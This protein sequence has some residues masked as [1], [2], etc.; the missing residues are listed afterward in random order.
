MIEKIKIFI[1][2]LIRFLSYDIWRI[3]KK[4]GP[5]RKIG[6]YN[7]IKSFILAIRNIDGA[8]LFTRAS[9]LTYSTLL[10]IVPL[11][12][13]LFAIARGF[14]FQNIVKSQLFS[15]FAGQ[16]ELLNKATAFID[17]SIEYAQGG[18]FL[19]IGVVLLLYT[20]IN[21]LSNIEDNF[22]RMWQVKTGRSY[23]RM[24]TDYLALIIITP[25]FLICNAGITII[26]NTTAEQQYFLG[27]VMSPIMKIVPFLIII[28]L[29]TILY[30]Y[31][32]N[33]KVKF[34]SAL[35]GGIFTGIAFQIFQVL[36]INGQMWISKYNAIYGS[37]AALPLLLLWLQLTWFFILFGVQLSFSFQNVN[38]FN[39]EHETSNISRR[40]KDF[41]TLLIMTLIVKR[42]EKGHTPYTA[43]E[44]SEYYKIPT[45][46][47]S[48]TLFHLL[49]VGMVVET[50][51]EDN[52]VP[53][54]IPSLDINH[55]T[56]GFLFEKIDR[57]GSEDFMIDTDIQFQSEWETILRI[58]EFDNHPDGKKLLKDL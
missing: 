34:K 27:L 24:F 10:S 53:A 44:L 30:I 36:Y 33:T 32:P 17:K 43:D 14:G 50:P 1:T 2:R 16:E 13:V 6:F 15:Y 11:L 29:F 56:V 22:N 23:F 51:T 18:V 40:Y 54:Y 55:I 52:L 12:A 38:K 39:F 45:K 20:V 3:N 7:I 5:S 19:G 46:L 41:V 42:F 58:R 31:I 21:L 35:F 48:D 28:L 26:L 4:D 9:A 57:H 8:Q 25:V 37:F 47:T 49:E